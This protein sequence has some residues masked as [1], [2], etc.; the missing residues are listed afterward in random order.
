MQVLRFQYLLCS[1]KWQGTKAAL[2]LLGEAL[3]CN[4]PS[5]HSLSLTLKVA[6]TYLISMHRYWMLFVFICAIDWSCLH[7]HT[8]LGFW[9]MVNAGHQ[10]S[11]K[12]TI[13]HTVDGQQAPKNPTL[14]KNGLL[15]DLQVAQWWS[16][17]LQPRAWS[18]RSRIKSCMGIPAW[19]LL[20]PLPVSLPLPLSL[21][22]CVCLSWINK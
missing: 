13:N 3:A 2:S 11:R 12:Q 1:D 8:F 20:L 17:C 19:S 15:R 10:L 5:P 6:I 7:S 21:S 4:S 18:W 16:V 14:G 9:M 22:L